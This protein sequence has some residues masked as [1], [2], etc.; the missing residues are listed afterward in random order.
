MTA[1][2]HAPGLAAIMGLRDELEL[3]GIEMNTFPSSTFT[4]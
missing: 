3:Q 4:G 1:G 2:N